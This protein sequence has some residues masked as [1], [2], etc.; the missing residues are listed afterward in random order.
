MR[1]MAI[2]SDRTSSSTQEITASLEE[3]HALVNT[4]CNNI[5]KLYECIDGLN[6][7][8]TKFKI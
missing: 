3:Q 6:G 2:I 8:V 1:N 7:S 5:E 4:M